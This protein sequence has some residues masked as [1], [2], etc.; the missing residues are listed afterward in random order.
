MSDKFIVIT[1]INEP[2]EAVRQYAKWKGWSVIVI[3][4]EK[5]PAEWYWP[6]VNYIGFEERD[7]SLPKNSYSRKILGYIYAIRAGAQWIFETDDDNIPYPHAQGILENMIEGWQVPESWRSENGWL[8]IH[9]LMGEDEWWPRGYPLELVKDNHMERGG[10]IKPWSIMQFMCNKDP[11]VD[12]I[13]R[14]TNDNEIYFTQDR[15]VVLEEGTFCTINSQATLWGKEAFPFML[16]P[17]MVPDRVTDIL[18]GLM[19]TVCCWSIGRSVAY[20]G[21]LVRQDR[22]PHN[23]LSDLNEEFQLYINTNRWSQLLTGSASF[24]ECIIRLCKDQTLSLLNVK[25]WELFMK[26]A[27]L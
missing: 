19:A 26:A 15:T 21:A 5:T 8:N 18:R 25:A 4:D 16:L 27:N 11:D 6:N 2:T 23:L 12:A 7:E 14:L 10:V 3:G 24:R 1:S 13:S 17:I 20:S 9:R 22:N